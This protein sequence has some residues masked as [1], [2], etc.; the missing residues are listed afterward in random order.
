MCM[1]GSDLCACLDQTCLHVWIRP[2]CM[3]GLD[4]STCMDRSCLH[5]WIRPV[6]IHLN[7]HLV[8]VPPPVLSEENKSF[9]KFTLSL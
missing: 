4:V 8:N 7:S 3:Y 1:Y 6:C 2:V 5:V 9:T